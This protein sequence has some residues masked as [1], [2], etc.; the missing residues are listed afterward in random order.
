MSSVLEAHPTV[1]KAVSL[2]IGT[3]LWAFLSPNTVCVD[4]VRCFT[5]QRLPY[6]SVPAK[7]VALDAF[8][9]TRY[10]CFVLLKDGLLMLLTVMGK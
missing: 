9:M 3:D 10:V 5:A 1:S 8:P 4:D 6:Y 7:Y 2:L